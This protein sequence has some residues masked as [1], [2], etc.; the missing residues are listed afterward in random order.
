MIE[1]LTPIQFYMFINTLDVS[2]VE[3]INSNVIIHAAVGDVKW[4]FDS[5][6]ELFCIKN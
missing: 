2:I 3:I 4:V 5:A 1:C 6:T